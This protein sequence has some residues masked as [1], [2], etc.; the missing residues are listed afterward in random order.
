MN[1][2]DF[3]KVQ[4]NIQSPHFKVEED[5]NNYLIAEVE[6]LVKTNN[7]LEKAEILLKI[8]KSRLGYE[9]IVEIKLYLPGMLLFAMAKNGNFKPAVKKVYVDLMEQ[10]EKAK[11]RILF[12]IFL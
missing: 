11:G 8:E 9:C 12:N 7:R 1:T 3:N 4:F 2:F 6:R 5:L 10:M